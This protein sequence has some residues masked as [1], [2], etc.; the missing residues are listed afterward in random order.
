MIRGVRYKPLIDDHLITVLLLLF[1][2][3]RLLRKERSIG[4]ES[5]SVIVLLRG[6]DRIIM[7]LLRGGEGSLT[8]LSSNGRYENLGGF[9]NSR[10][11]F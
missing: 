10:G 1:S 3:L 5:C 7:V 9:Y 2:V 6:Y 4:G 8:V 11:L